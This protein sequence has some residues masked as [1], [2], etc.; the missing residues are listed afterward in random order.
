MRISL[1][2]ISVILGINT[3][4]AQDSKALEWLSD[5]TT[6]YH[7]V[8]NVD[9]SMTTL[10]TGYVKTVVVGDTII[11]G[12]TVKIL[13]Q[14]VV[15]GEDRFVYNS[16]IYLYNE[17]NKVYAQ[18]LKLEDNE[19]GLLYD[20]DAMQ[21]DTIWIKESFDQHGEL[22]P[23]VIDSTYTIEIEG[24]EFRAIDQNLSYDYFYWHFT[25]QTIEYI[26]FIYHLLP[27]SMWTV[28]YNYDILGL[29][30]FSSGD[31]SWQ[32]NPEIPCDTLYSKVVVNV[33]EL[34][35]PS[36]FKLFPNPSSSS[37]SLSFPSLPENLLKLEIL[38][39]NGRVIQYEL[40]EPEL[41]IRLNI[42]HLKPATYI[43]RVF[44][45]NKWVTRK[46]IRN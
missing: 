19:F 1:I 28:D 45:N 44:A 43:L 3:S 23:V 4:Q 35:S 18:T 32:V 34:H 25:G 41:L 13:S 6:W 14:E 5:G 26:G 31:F 39:M 15:T 17:G 8:T 24:V 33:D 29:R 12:K 20:F 11:D 40:L 22:L 7:T 46:F 27:K 38:D 9:F 42:E 10:L 30:C 2:I 16:E 37:I 36:D 21:G